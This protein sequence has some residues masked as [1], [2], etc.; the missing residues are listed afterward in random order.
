[1]KNI[2]YYNLFVKRGKI[3]LIG[4][5]TFCGDDVQSSNL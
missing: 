4:K 3:S 5:M 1:M 2:I